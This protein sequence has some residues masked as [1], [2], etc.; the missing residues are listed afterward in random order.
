[1]ARGFLG[2]CYGARALGD[3]SHL[4]RASDEVV[5]PWSAKG[6]L[7]SYRLLLP[8]WWWTRGCGHTG[9]QMRQIGFKSTQSYGFGQVLVPFLVVAWPQMSARI[10]RLKGDQCHSSWWH[11][12]KGGRFASQWSPWHGVIEVL[13]A[14][15]V[16]SSVPP[17][18]DPSRGSFGLGHNLLS[19][20]WSFLH[21]L[22]P[23]L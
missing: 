20:F 21:Y 13:L 23:Y 8:S 1:M 3:C 11:C 19:L 6:P 16:P 5:L 12:Q 9:C 2:V 10:F 18:L 22:G 4:I 17:G 14:Q 15:V 7:A